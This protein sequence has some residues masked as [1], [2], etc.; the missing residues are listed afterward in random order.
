MNRLKRLLGKLDSAQKKFISD[1]KDKPV[2]TTMKVTMGEPGRLGPRGNRGVVGP[3]GPIGVTGA[4]G[5]AGFIGPEGPTGDEGAEGPKGAPGDQGDQGR[6]GVKGDRGEPG[7]RGL[8][9]VNG[10]TGDQGPPGYPGDNGPAGQDGTKGGPGPAGI[11]PP[12]PPGPPGLTG[13]RGPK[14]DTG[15]KGLRGE[16]GLPGPPGAQG[17]QGIT[18]GTG[19]PGKDGPMLPIPKC[20]GA[21]SDD[22]SICH[23]ES[24]VNWNSF[25]NSGAYLDID[26]SPCKMSNDDVQYFTFLTGNAYAESLTGG[27]AI[28][29]P[30]KNGFRVYVAS[31]I[32][33]TQGWSPVQGWVM[34]QYRLRVSWVAVGKSTG[35]KST[36]V[37]CGTG[38]SKWA[39]SGPQ[40]YQNVDAGA[41]SMKGSPVWI[42]A[43][44]GGKAYGTSAFIGTNAAYSVGERFAMMFIRQSDITK[45]RDGGF[46]A[47][48]LS[49]GKNRLVPK[50][51]QFG[52]PFP[53]GEQALD[54]GKISLDEYPCM[55]MRVVKADKKIVTNTAGMCC[56][57]TDNNWESDSLNQLSKRVDTSA[58][59]FQDDNVVYITSLGGNGDHWR[60]TGDTAYSESSSSSF[61]TKLLMHPTQYSPDKAK[62][63]DWHINWC[64]VGNRG[65]KKVH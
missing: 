19:G 16:E 39:Q 31:D 29:S 25:Y 7:P 21:V 55:G 12:G 46:S 23:G 2:Q 22:K 57:K 14:G 20:K 54:E 3:Q 65:L 63:L 6:Q 42:T 34:N 13:V 30:T 27:S 9:G 5:R 61:V 51:C 48:E 26:T 17:I 24:N 37:C 47:A 38:E 60:T 32:A 43:A 35:P 41:C 59:G 44:E 40:S 10:R 18:G 28:Y 45:A 50:Y 4:Q 33:G 64:G 62:A 15:A 49:S 36:A 8:P 1:L 52:E 53:S 56:G 58:C 11:A